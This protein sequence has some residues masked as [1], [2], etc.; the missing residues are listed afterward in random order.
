MMTASPDQ[1][2]ALLTYCIDFAKTMLSDSGEFYPFGANLGQ[3]GQVRAV[4]G[5]DGNERPNP[6]DIYRL[7][8]ES[9]VSNAREGSITAAALAA[10]VNI[11]AEYSP[12]V[13]DG[14]R[15]HLESADLSRF[16]Y[17]PYRVTKRGLFKKKFEVE[18]F[19]PIP[20]ETPP[21]IFTGALN[22]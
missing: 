11:P 10:N 6:Q 15:V 18:F 20:V 22:A 21:S 9:F 8:G 4:G 1:L 17:V 16:V 5:Y 7:L 14:L 2:H 19:N 13:P 3:D 12:P